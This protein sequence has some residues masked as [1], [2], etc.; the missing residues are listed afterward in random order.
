M[1]YFVYHFL[2]N[3]QQGIANCE[4]SPQKARH[5]NKFMNSREVSSK[6]EII[7]QLIE[8]EV[9][10]FDFSLNRLALEWNWMSSISLAFVPICSA[11]FFTKRL[12][13]L[14]SMS[15]ANDVN[16]LHVP[17]KN[18]KLQVVAWKIQNIERTSNVAATKNV[19]GVFQSK[20]TLWWLFDMKKNVFFEKYIFKN[21]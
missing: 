4:K 3:D 12:E 2:L 11:V 16:I 21:S 10:L 14:V 5:Q 7:F 15:L 13:T 9:N 18:V 1:V 6:S 8:N 17:L 19:D 20:G